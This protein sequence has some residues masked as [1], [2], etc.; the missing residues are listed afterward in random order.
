MGGMLRQHVAKEVELYPS[1]PQLSLRFVNTR[2]N[3]AQGTSSLEML[4][5]GNKSLQ[6]DLCCSSARHPAYEQMDRDIHKSKHV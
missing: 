3:F 4:G 6:Y 5:V 2:V 1:T